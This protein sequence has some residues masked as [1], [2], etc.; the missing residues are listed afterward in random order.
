MSRSDLD[1]LRDARDF[2]RHAFSHATG[3]D[4]DVLAQAL[5]P[6]HAAF[7]ALAVVGEALSK[8]PADL[9]SAAPAIQWDA[10]VALR[11]HLVHAYWQI[12]LEIIAGIIKNRI[13]PL[14]AELEK[15]IALVEKMDA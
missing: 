14:V 10:I 13:H 4:G 1:R 9:R 6:Q 15:L 7:Y 5:Q 3:L 8:I 11:N 2:A 12:D